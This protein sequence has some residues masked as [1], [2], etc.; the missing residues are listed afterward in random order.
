MKNIMAV[1]VAFALS[2][3]ASIAFATTLTPSRIGWEKDGDWSFT[4]DLTYNGNGCST[5]DWACGYY[6]APVRICDADGM[7]A[8]A[9]LD[10]NDLYYFNAY[11]STDAGNNW[12]TQVDYEGCYYSRETGAYVCRG[13]EQ[14][15]YTDWA[16]PGTNQTDPFMAFNFKYSS[17]GIMLRYE[18]EVL[19]CVWI[20]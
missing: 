7:Y 17:A 8:S 12:I 18:F 14:E 9:N 13:S 4:T 10:H 2:S 20:E 5:G 16:A 15:G 11:Y 1:F 19:S 3:V 6:S